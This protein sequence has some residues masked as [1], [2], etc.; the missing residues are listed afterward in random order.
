VKRAVIE[1]QEREAVRSGGGEV[2]E[3]E[4]KALGV[5]QRQSE[6]EAGSGQGLHC[7]VQR[8]ALTA[9]GAGQQGLDAA[10]RDTATH[11]GQQTAATFVLGPE[12]P[13]GRAVLL[14]AV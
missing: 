13:P 5:E 9:I 12:A 1:Q 7:A 6:K 3:E 2:I 8:E 10:G 14:D 4:W 11:D